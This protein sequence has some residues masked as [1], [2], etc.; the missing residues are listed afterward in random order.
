[1]NAL[2]NLVGSH[3][4]GE[5]DWTFGQIIPL[6]LLLSSLLPIFELF[7]KSCFMSKCLSE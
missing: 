1:M 6:A 4:I 3:K 5:N 7:Y 2:K